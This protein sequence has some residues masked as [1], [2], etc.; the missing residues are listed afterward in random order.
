MDVE[1]RGLDGIRA[2]QQMR[3]LVPNCAVVVLTMCGGRE[4]RAKALGAGAQAFIEK[5]G[6]AEPLLREIRRLAPYVCDQPVTIA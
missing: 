3:D 5:Q 4:T 2:I 6:G 1:M